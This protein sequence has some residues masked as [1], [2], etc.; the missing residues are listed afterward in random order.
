M[1]AAA[2]GDDTTSAHGS[3]YDTSDAEEEDPV[4]SQVVETYHGA[5]EYHVGKCRCASAFGQDA[6]LFASG[7][8]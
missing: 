6:C 7:V 8:F 1:A 2:E 4:W 3:D 5:T